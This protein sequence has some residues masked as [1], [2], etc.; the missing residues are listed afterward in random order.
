M[1]LLSLFTITTT[2]LVLPPSAAAESFAT[3]EKLYNAG[4]WQKAAKMALALNSSD[5]YALAARCYTAGTAVSPY[6]K[7]KAMFET[8]Q[9]YAKKAIAKDPKNA[10]A[11][12]ELGRALGR[13]GEFVGIIQSLNLAKDMKKNLEKA[14]ALDPKLAGPYVGLGL[15][16]ANIEG[17]GFAAKLATGAS[18]DQILPNFKKAFALEPRNAIHRIEFVNALIALGDKKGATH[19]MTLATK[20]KRVGYWQKLSYKTALANLKK[21]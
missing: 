18:R 8:S 6:N 2:L 19:Q 9:G 12:F 16:H 17:K 10:L 14:I 11:Y 1:R 20:M 7:R 15:W 5:G 4:E 3:A 21:M 13:M